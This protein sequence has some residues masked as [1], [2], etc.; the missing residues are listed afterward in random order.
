MI[1]TKLLNRYE[2]VRELGRGG[3]GVVY[4]AR[5]PVLDREVAVKV[6]TPEQVSTESVERF[7]REARVVARMDHPSIVTVYD[8]GEQEGAL[9]FIMPL[10]EG[11]NLRSVLKSQTLRLGELV[12]I[13]IQIADALEYSH[14]RV[15][16][17]GTSS[18]KTSW[19]RERKE[20]GSAFALQI[21]DLR[22]LRLMT[23]SRKQQP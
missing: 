7:R 8:S 9:F 20:K 23:V 3:M 6:V 13:A 18:R 19:L 14:S 1:G 15:L 17:T 4:L 5:D 12:D 21:L 11:T 10:V 16:C 2:I 22:W